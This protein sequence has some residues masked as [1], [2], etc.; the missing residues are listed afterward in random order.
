PAGVRGGLTRPR[1]PQYRQRRPGDDPE[2]HREPA[3]AAIQPI[4]RMPAAVARRAA[5][6]DLPQPGEPRTG[7]CEEDLRAAARKFA[8]AQRSRPD[9]RHLTLENIQELRKFVDTRRPQRA[10]EACDPRVAIELAGI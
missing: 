3:P 1:P 4:K 9:D 5:P 7:R 6:E 8:R 2:I 10:P